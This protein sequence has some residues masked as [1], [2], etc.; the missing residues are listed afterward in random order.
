MFLEIE[1]LWLTLH[2]YFAWMI[3]FGNS[4][5]RWSVTQSVILELTAFA[6][7]EKQN[8]KQNEFYTL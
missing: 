2:S 4:L 1:N 7:C 6:A 5:I 8:P 3:A